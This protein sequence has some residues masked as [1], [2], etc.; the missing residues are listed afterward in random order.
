[1]VRIDVAVHRLYRWSFGGGDSSSGVVLSDRDYPRGHTF[2][3]DALAVLVPAINPLSD[4][5]IAPGC[6]IELLCERGVC[7]RGMLG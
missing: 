1:V 6:G 3:S 4:S 5:R 7:W 2:T